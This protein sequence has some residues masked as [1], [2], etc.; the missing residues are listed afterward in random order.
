M[1][2]SILFYYGRAARTDGPCMGPCISRARPM[3][4]QV[5]SA[6]IPLFVC[7]SIC[8]FAMVMRSGRTGLPAP[9]RALTIFF[10]AAC[11]QWLRS[12]YGSSGRKGRNPSRGRN[13]RR[14][15]CRLSLKV[16]FLFHSACT[17]GY[18]SSV[19][20]DKFIPIR[21]AFD[22]RDAV[23]LAL[24]ISFFHIQG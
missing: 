4:A 9:S 21:R 2:V 5:F 16:S 12:S 20:P 14:G 6:E 3:R 10:P 15:R 13:F 8:E 1:C 17:P 23:R 19:C 7:A 22:R 24:P 18:S 11:H